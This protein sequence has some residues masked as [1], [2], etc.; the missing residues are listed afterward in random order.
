MGLN[1]TRTES[2]LI[3]MRFRTTKQD[4]VL[5]YAD[6]N[7]G[8]FIALE[9]QKG[10]VHF[11]IDLGWYLTN[12]LTHSLIHHFETVPDSIKLQTTTEMQLL[13]DFKIQIA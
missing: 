2:D 3:M 12:V 7:Q 13:K 4:G 10:Y 1:A 5:L 11:R 9:L 8:D 6:G